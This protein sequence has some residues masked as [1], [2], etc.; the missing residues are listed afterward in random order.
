MTRSLYYKEYIKVIPISIS[1]QH[2][3]RVNIM[4]CTWR[5]IYSYLLTYLLCISMVIFY[6]HP[7]YSFSHGYCIAVPSDTVRIMSANMLNHFTSRPFRPKFYT[8]LL[9]LIF[10]SIWEYQLIDFTF[11]PYRSCCCCMVHG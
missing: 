5:L 9:Q 7:A 2:H 6:C 11:F 3:G 8:W 4:C 10:L 1:F